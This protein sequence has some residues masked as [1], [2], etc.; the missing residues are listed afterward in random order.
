M[1]PP[2]DHLFFR[3]NK[4]PQVLTSCHLRNDYLSDWRPLSFPSSIPLP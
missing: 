3:E 1:S 2:D 4:H